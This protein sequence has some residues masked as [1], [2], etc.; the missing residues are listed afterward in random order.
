MYIDDRSRD[1]KSLRDN[2]LVVKYAELCGSP[3]DTIDDIFGHIDI[4]DENFE[5]V[6]G[7]YQRVLHE[8]SYYSVKFSDKEKKDIIE[9]ANAEAETFGYS[10]GR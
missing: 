9:T 3:E 8:P 5:R 4:L 6:K 1:D 2:S 7:T 10:I